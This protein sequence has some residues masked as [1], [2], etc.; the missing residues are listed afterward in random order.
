MI[1]RISAKFIKSVL[2]TIVSIFKWKRIVPII[3]VRDANKL[4]DGKVALITGASGGIGLAIA[5]KLLESGCKVVLSG[6]NEEKLRL[7]ASEI[8]VESFLTIDINEI[9]LF[10]SKVNEAS[11]FYGKID[12]YINCHGIHTKR[13]GFDFL[14][15]TEEEYK[16]VMDINLKGTYFMCQ[17][18]ALYMIK[19]KIK[20]HILIVSSQSALE[21]SWS[22]Y[23]LSK[24]GISGITAGIAKKMLPYGIVVNAIG[25]G[26]TA[27]SMQDECI[28]GSIYTSDNPIQRYT[29]PDEV[30]EYAKLLVSH[31]GDT[32]VGETLYM[33]GGR[34]TIDMR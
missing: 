9:H 8:G 11:K 6:T 5:S 12:I 24:L 30:A 20:G 7:K 19:N 21:P 10:D 15:V 13:N 23:R 17:K 32:I 33:S 26:P 28:R 4:L 34:G 16:S 25:P 2:I 1:M 29:L 22:P 27:T 31:L 14:N 18:V 3:A